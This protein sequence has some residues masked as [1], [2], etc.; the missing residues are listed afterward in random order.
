MGRAN[1]S[2]VANKAAAEGQAGK[3]FQAMAGAIAKVSADYIQRQENDEY[4]EAIAQHH[5]EIQDWKSRHDAKPFYTADEV[6]HLD[7]SDE[8]SMHTYTDDNGV[9]VTE[10]RGQIHAH[11]VYPQLLQKK[12]A[13][14]IENRAQQISNPRMRNAFIE[15]AAMEASSMTMHAA[16]KAEVA[17]QK[18]VFEKT[19]TAAFEAADNGQLAMAQ[20]QIEQLED[21][22]DLT[23]EKLMTEVE[24]RVEGYEVTMAIRSTEPK[25]ILTM[26]ALLDDPN[27]SGHLTEKA[28]Q[29][30]IR[31]L[32]N[33][34]D[35]LRSEFIASQAKAHAAF[36][37]DAYYGIEQGTFTL[38]DVE[39]GYQ[40]WHKNDKDPTAITAQERTALR[41]AINR[42]NASLKAQEDLVARGASIFEN[43]GDR[44]DPDDQKAI[45]AFV[46]NR[47][48]TDIRDLEN[49]ALRSSVMPSVLSRA[50]NVAAL[51]DAEKGAD[52]IGPLVETYARLRAQ[53][54]DL[55]RELNPESQNL[56]GDMEIMMR[57]NVPLAEAYETAREMNRMKP[58]LREQR[59]TEYRDAVKFGDNAPHLKNLMDEDES[60]YGF[61]G[62]VFDGFN[63]SVVPPNSEMMGQFNAH[64]RSHYIRTGDLELSR[65]RAYQQIQEKWSPTGL[66]G[67]MTADGFDRSQRPMEYAPERMMMV[68]TE[69]AQARL[70]AFARH[71]GLE[72]K[73][74][75]VM[76][77]DRTARD[78]SWAIFVLDE[79][80]DTLTFWPNRWVG[81]DWA[82]EA[83]EYTWQEAVK[84]E[85]EKRADM[86]NML[87]FQKK[88]QGNPFWLAEDINKEVE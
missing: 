28:R 69:K 31:D 32:N 4:N 56:L 60:L 8:I 37:S 64:V 33:R 18:Y 54:P 7:N 40:L 6:A 26:R 85:V 78:G 23:R 43:G 25:T 75:N 15:N 70:D 81:V 1:L 20:F 84:V 13:G 66:G 80:T 47:G 3:A 10:R 2:S 35:Y 73:T 34:Y 30:A 53:K 48:F 87:E 76:S 9:Q 44:A 19:T 58:E 14:M 63:Q 79:E 50:F 72:G 46:A 88:A 83:D 5:I 55:M 74:L 65:E 67:R 52:R 11:E 39:E 22:D 49:V 77:D 68:S 12:L 29:A 62:G 24:A 36:I 86:N 16:V 61:E 27:Y 82:D 42:R 17:Q 45:D 51:H 21:I 71:E 38:K 41:N 57:G 59:E